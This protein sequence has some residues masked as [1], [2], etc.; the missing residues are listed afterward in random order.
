MNCPNERALPHEWLP[1]VFITA[2]LIALLYSIW[3]LNL[4][5]ACAWSP[6]WR[7]LPRVTIFALAV[8]AALLLQGPRLLPTLPS[9]FETNT[10]SKQPHTGPLSGRMLFL[11]AVFAAALALILQNSSANFEMHRV[12]PSAVADLKEQTQLTGTWSESANNLWFHAP[13]GEYATGTVTLLVRFE[14]LIFA[15]LFFGTWAGRGAREG[16][17][18]FALI[19]C[20]AASDIWLTWKY[21]PE[22]SGPLQTFPLLRLPFVPSIGGFCPSPTLLDVFFAAAILEAAR[23]LRLHPLSLAFGAVAGYASAA[24]LALE[25]APGISFLSMSLAGSGIMAGAWPDLRLD[26]TSAGK[27]FFTAALLILIL[28]ASTALHHKLN[29]IPRPEPTL[30]RRSVAFLTPDP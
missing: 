30:D 13:P 4:P 29:P 12:A 16:W 17:H 15:A 26:A 19:L 21:P 20:A 8:I 10:P 24:F 27:A 23:V 3:L 28:S 11:G 14:C 1:R 6:K 18:F 25:P 7:M 22:S 9:P 2:A 5:Y